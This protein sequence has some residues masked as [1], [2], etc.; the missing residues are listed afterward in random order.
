MHLSDALSRLHTHQPNK[1]LTLPGMDIT[2]HEVESCT[3]FSTVSLGKIH[4]ATLRDQDLQVLKTHIIN[5]FPLHTNQCLESIRPF[6][7]YREELTI[8]NGLIL[9][10]SCIVIPTE[11]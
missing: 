6:F 2:V 7:P 5:G 3:N 9:K 4:D 11:L 1:G 8:F 10:G